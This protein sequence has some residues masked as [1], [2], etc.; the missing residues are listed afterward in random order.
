MGMPGGVYGARH[1]VL[2]RRKHIWNSD[3][4]ALPMSVVD[5]SKERAF[6]ALVCPPPPLSLN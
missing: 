4:L 6:P 3:D 5:S 1:N 2:R